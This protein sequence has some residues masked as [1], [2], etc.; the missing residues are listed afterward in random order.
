MT[1]LYI[2]LLDGRFCLNIS[3]SL[4]INSNS[5]F[6]RIKEKKTNNK[7]NALEILIEIAIF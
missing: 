4:A 5:I 3:I 7:W 2:S 6:Q 1:Q